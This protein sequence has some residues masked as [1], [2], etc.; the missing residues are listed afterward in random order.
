MSKHGA[1]LGKHGIKFGKDGVFAEKDETFAEKHGT[2]A[3]KD[4]TFAQFC[5]VF[6][7]KLPAFAQLF[8]GRHRKRTTMSTDY[9]PGSKPAMQIWAANFVSVCSANQ[10]TLGLTSSDMMTLTGLQSSFVSGVA[11]V[12]TA[13]Q[14]LKAAVANETLVTKSFTGDIRG[15]VRRFQTN[16]AVLAPLKESLGINPRNTPKNRTPPV[17]PTG[18]AVEG[19][20][21]GV[22]TVK[23]KRSGNKPSTIFRIQAQVGTSTQFVEVGSTAALTFDHTGQTPGVKVAYRVVAYRA[24]QASV[25][26]TQVVVYNGGASAGA[27][28]GTTAPALTLQKAA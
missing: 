2:F 24:K 6:A 27:T 26:S 23:W 4:E 1:K 19:A 9:I 16:P 14:A 12:K 3:E 5:A 22:N 20:S 25:P 21:T 7:E 10:A 18:L 8:N 13:K 15:L 17:T 11:G 28:T